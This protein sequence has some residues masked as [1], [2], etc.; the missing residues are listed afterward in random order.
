MMSVT[1][2][3]GDESPNKVRNNGIITIRISHNRSMNTSIPTRLINYLREELSIPSE[4]IAIALRHREE[5]PSQLPMVLWKYGL[6]TIEQLD[7]IFDWL[8]TETA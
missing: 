5:M 6:V 1:A 7:K 4:S 2:Y 3:S 8:E